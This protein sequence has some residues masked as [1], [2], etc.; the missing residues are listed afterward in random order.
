MKFVRFLAILP[1]VAVCF[2]A[3]AA[4]K[5]PSHLSYPQEPTVIEY[6]VD[7]T[8]PQRPESFGAPGGV[9]S[10]VVDR[11]DRIWCLERCDEPVQVYSTDGKLIASWGRDR[12]AGPHSLRFDPEGHVWIADFQRHTVEKFTTDGKLLLTLGTPGEAGEDKSHFYRPTDMAVTPAGDIFVTDG[13]GNRRVVH[14][15]GQ[16][17]FVKS[18]GRYGSGP[19]EFVLPHMIVVDSQGILYVADR[20]SGRIQ[21]FRQNGEFI[22][23]W[24]NLIMPWG[25]SIFGADEIWCCGTS[26]QRWY[27][28]G[29]YPPPKDQI[30]MRFSSDGKLRQL[31]TV[32]KAE[33]GQEKP[34]ECNW[35][36]A[37]AVD[38]QGNVYLG[39]ING[40]RAQKF[41][42]SAAP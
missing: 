26:P 18:W 3:G 31:W 33:D 20:N 22:D 25:L 5:L 2:R 38:S 28:N 14:F 30:F 37:I 34:G 41:I 42:R 10:I 39:D 15:D 8:W 11:E 16:G 35:L 40:K 17:R 7:P 36:H 23:Q 32:P 27:S 21:L 24:A 13:Y 19:G 9:P 6:A 4:E 29:E 1:I 12:F